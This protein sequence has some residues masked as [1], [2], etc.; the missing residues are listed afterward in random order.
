MTRCL[1]PGSRLAV[2]IASLA[3]AA[4]VVGAAARAPASPAGAPAAPDAERG[5]EGFVWIDEQ[6]VTH[7]SNDPSAVP[8]AAARIDEERDRLRRLWDDGVVGPPLV[9][10][11]RRSGSDR[12][13]VHR[14]LA[15]V[16]A[17][18]ERGEEARAAATL[19]SVM[20]L[21]PA[22]AEPH[23]YLA[24]LDQRRGRHASARAHLEVVLREGPLA[25]RILSHLGPEPAPPRE[26]LAR[27]YRA[28]CDALAA[29]RTFRARA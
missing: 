23:W 28:L 20:R 10:S 26:A 7:L 5:A 1:V 8:E 21:D 25:R 24:V 18:L 15:G 27:V 19:R 17:D 29:G 2:A 16:A 11:P 22:L 6:G 12:G 13:R 14:L 9:T 3:A 4:A